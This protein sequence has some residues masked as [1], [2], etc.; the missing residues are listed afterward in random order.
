MLFIYLFFKPNFTQQMCFSYI[1]LCTLVQFG[2]TRSTSV[3]FNPLWFYLVHFGP[4]RSNLLRSY[5]VQ[6]G[7]IRST[8]VIF[9]QLCPL[10]SYL[11][12]STL[13]G[14]NRSTLVLFGPFCILQFYLVQFGHIRSTLVLFGSL[15]LYS[16]HYVHV[17]S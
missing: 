8:L 11:V 12:Y 1:L 13:F 15:W 3:L 2:L 14:P 16:V 7:T 5:S 4:I 10:W 9:S 6:L 17:G